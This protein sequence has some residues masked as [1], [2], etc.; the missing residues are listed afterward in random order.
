MAVSIDFQTH[1]PPQYT[2]RGDSHLPR[3]I[4]DLRRFLAKTQKDFTHNTLRLPPQ[5]LATL[6]HVLVEFGEDI[7]NN[8]GIWQTLEQYNWELFGT[9]LPLTL[10]AGSAANKPP[11]LADRLHHLLWVLYTEIEPD[12]IFSPQHL[13]LCHLATAVADFLSERLTNSPQHS[14]VKRFLS[15]PNK[16]GWDVKRKLVWLGQHSYLFRYQCQN[17]VAANGE[18]AN[19][20]TIDDFICQETTS[21]SGLGVI[22]ILAG[23]LPLSY[24]QQE[25]LRGWYQRHLAYYQIKASKGSILKVINLINNE[26]YK[27][28]MDTTT[29]QFKPGTVVFGALVPW[30]GVWYWSGE[31]KIYHSVPEDVKKKLPDDML[32]RMPHIV[33]RYNQTLANRARE[34]L[35]HLHKNF[36]GYHGDNLAIYSGGISMAGDIQKM[37]RLHNESLPGTKKLEVMQKYNLDSAKPQM[38]YPPE[39]VK[40]EDGVAVFFNPDEGQEIFNHF[41]VLVSA[42]QKQGEDLSEDESW[43]VQGLIESGNLSPSFVHRLLQD[44][45]DASIAAAFIIRQPPAYYLEYLLRRHKGHFYRQR[46]PHVTLVK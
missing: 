2:G 14:G 15:Q 27:V 44:Y 30:E 35:D 11:K 4:R 33:Y 8:I 23:L 7:H 34:T 1:R 25:T 39:L 28:R 45:S 31:Q 22:D 19:I 16:F 17:Y 32:S 12:L 6:A 24:S 37:Y 5:E 29:T 9:P 42:L 21:W 43:A 18:Q 26:P 41:D 36:T 46:Y 10:L 20:G 3:M 38:P 13:D 40:S